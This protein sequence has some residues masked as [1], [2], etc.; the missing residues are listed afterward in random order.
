MEAQGPQGT[1][2]GW[3]QNPQG[4]GQRYWDGTRWTD[5]YSQGP[6]PP[7][8]PHQPKSGG[9][10]GWAK[11]LL[12]LLAAGTVVVVVGVVGCAALVGGT[13]N[14]IDRSIKEE[15]SSN[16]I[17]NEQARGVKLGTSRGAVESRFGPPKSDQEST[18]EGLGDDTCI[19]YNVRGGEILDQWQFCFGGSGKSG[20]LR[21]KNRL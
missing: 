10:P 2:P 1:P 6:Q 8:P 3:Y 18:N 9:M 15:Q 16:A 11:V 7:L 5:N 20:K 19:Y 17:T 14:E 13:A 21:S 4:P 12:G